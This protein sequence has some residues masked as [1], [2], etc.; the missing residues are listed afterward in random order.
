MPSTPTVAHAQT[1]QPAQIMTGLPVF[2]IPRM[3]LSKNTSASSE[4]SKIE[5][6]ENETNEAN[7]VKNDRQRGL[8]KRGQKKSNRGNSNGGCSSDGD[9]TGVCGEGRAQTSEKKRLPNINGASGTEHKPC[10]E[11]AHWCEQNGGTRNNTI[12]KSTREVN[13]E[14]CEHWGL[15]R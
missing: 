9:C 3:A 2:I 6:E 12:C 7:A 14:R 15:G 5:K 4:E 11:I 1:A 10:L 8:Q 13:A